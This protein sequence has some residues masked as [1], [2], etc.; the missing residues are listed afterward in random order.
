MGAMSLSK[1]LPTLMQQLSSSI[2][3]ALAPEL[4]IDWA[5]RDMDGLLR[6][7]NR[8]MA[9]TSCIMT[10]PLAGIMVFGDRFYELWVPTE[11]APLLWALTTLAIFGYVFTSG[12]Q[13]LYNVFTTVNKVRS[14]AV[15]VLVSG[16]ASILVTLLLVGTTQ[17]GVYAVAGV[18]SIANLVRNMAF[19]VPVTAKY[20]GCKWHQ[21]FP[22]VG[23]TAVATVALVLMGIL[24][25]AVIPGGSWALFL[26]AIAVFAVI[27]FLFNIFFMLNKDEREALARKIS[28]KL[29]G[30]RS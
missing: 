19:T 3:N 10:V 14:N 20:L 9:L 24:V 13:I 2:C 23:K 29:K 28:G 12:T 7:I 27:G 8:A 4:I 6:N 16:I 21:F 22:Q 25:R 17:L 15:A 30:A 11:D 26:V 18:S 5:H 1:T